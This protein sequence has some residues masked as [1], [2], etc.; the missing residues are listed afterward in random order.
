M[1]GCGDRAFLGIKCTKGLEMIPIEIPAFRGL[2]IKK[3]ETMY[4]TAI[5][6]EDGKLFMFGNNEFSQT[7]IIGSTFIRPTQFLSNKF[8]KDVAVGDSH[9]LFVTGI[10]LLVLLTSLDDGSVYSMG[11]NKHYQLGIKNLQYI[12]NIEIPQKIQFPGNP[13]IQSVYA[14]FLNSMFITN[15]GKVFVTGQ[16]NCSQLGIGTQED[17][18]SGPTLIEALSH[19]VICQ[20]ACGPYH[21]LFLEKWVESK[22]VMDV[23]CFSL[24][25]VLI[26]FTT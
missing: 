20:V 25:D 4:H 2:A 24:A 6:T 19:T 17:A 22:I 7:G 8:I 15:T 1:Y 3:I 14:G 18:Y 9:T 10:Q 16:N 11:R 12:S 23:K 21:S 5:L 26:L 13:I